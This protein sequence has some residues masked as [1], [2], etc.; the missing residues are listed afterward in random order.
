M[1]KNLLFTILLGLVLMLAAC[2]GDDSDTTSDAT[3]NT[4]TGTT[5]ESAA[6]ETEDSSASG[7]AA[8]N[9]EITVIGTDFAFDQEEYVVQ[10]GE[11]VTL[12]FVNEEGNHGI[13]I[14][15]FDVNIEG[16]GQATFTPEE[17]GEY[18]IYCNIFC[19]EG[20]GEMVVT[21]VVL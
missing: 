21:L 6:E 14:D 16:N 8:P 12:T 15:E 4:D 9:N 5:E 11:E 13:S 3:D 10:S 17:P 19:G 1:K 2:G 20:H 7:E 18:E